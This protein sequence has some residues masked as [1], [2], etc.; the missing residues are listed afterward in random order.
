MFKSSFILNLLEIFAPPP[1]TTQF[2]NVLRVNCKDTLPRRVSLSIYI[3]SI[4]FLEK[5]SLTRPFGKISRSSWRYLDPLDPL[6]SPTSSP[7]RKRKTVSVY[8]HTYPIDKL[9]TDR[10][11]LAPDTHYWAES[12]RSASFLSSSRPPITI[13]YIVNICS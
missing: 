1:T 11:M 10:E 8:I 7:P 9:V 2:Y 5:P 13:Q 4:P 12:E 3:F 6:V